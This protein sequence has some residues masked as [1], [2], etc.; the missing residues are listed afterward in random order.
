MTN[1]FTN[2]GVQPS[3]RPLLCWRRQRRGAAGEIDKGQLPIGEPRRIRD[4]EHL[5]FVASQLCLFC[6]R[7]PCDAHHLRFAQPRTTGKRV[8]DEFTVPLC[9]I[10]H[11][12]FHDAGNEVAWWAGI[13]PL[14]IAKEFWEESRAERVLSARH[15]C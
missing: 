11:P 2:G 7:Q 3:G 12:Q 10:H 9:R 6:S 14:E 15:C 8:A 13:S 4:K 1:I 5:K